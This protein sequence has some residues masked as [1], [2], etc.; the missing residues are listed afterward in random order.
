R[1]RRRWRRACCR[2]NRRSRSSRRNRRRRR[3][4]CRHRK[5]EEASAKGPTVGAS[6]L[7]WAPS[8]RRHYTHILSKSMALIRELYEL[9]EAKGWLAPEE[10]RALSARLRVPLY[11][12]QGLASFYPHFRLS[13]PP[14]ATVTVCRDLACHLRGAQALAKEIRAELAPDAGIEVVL[15][16]CIGRCEGAPACAVQDRPIAPADAESVARAAR[17][18]D[19]LPGEQPV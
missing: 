18:P 11:R 15:V 4:R 19:A 9:Q 12:L 10:L 6:N 7:L 2:P 17:H 16:S 8:R 3:W 14:R 1:T 5:Q 13:P